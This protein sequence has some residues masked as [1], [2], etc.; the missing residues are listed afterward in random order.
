[1]NEAIQER[2]NIGE[3]KIISKFGALL[4]NFVSQAHRTFFEGFTSDS[5]KQRSRGSNNDIN[6][7]AQE[8]DK[9]FN[10]YLFIYF[11]KTI[12]DP[13]TRRGVINKITSNQNLSRVADEIG[14]SDY[15]SN[16]PTTFSTH[17]KGTIIEALVQALYEHTQGNDIEFEKVFSPLAE[18]MMK[19]V[20]LPLA[21]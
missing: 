13:S 5:A 1:M 16:L 19:G 15:Y 21:S 14:V 8:G 17:C 11:K 9:T 4:S 12:P 6:V 2:P 10:N 20:S 3:R 7:L 18:N